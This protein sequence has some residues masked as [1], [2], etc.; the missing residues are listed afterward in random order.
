ML[1]PL[2]YGAEAFDAWIVARSADR[3][4]RADGRGTD[5]QGLAIDASS[6]GPGLLAIPVEILGVGDLPPLGF[7][8]LFHPVGNGVALGVVDR[9]LAR[10]E[11]QL[12]LG[13]QSLEEV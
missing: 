10:L 11:G 12:D 3:A 7:L 1:Y 5:G 13:V 4:H 6:M 9:H 2:S 8:G